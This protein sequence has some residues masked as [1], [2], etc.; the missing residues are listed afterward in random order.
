MINVTS[1]RAG[2]GYSLLS[3]GTERPLILLGRGTFWVL[4][5]AIPGEA[6]PGAG[7]SSLGLGCSCCVTASSRSA[8]YQCS[9]ESPERPPSPKSRGPAGGSSPQRGPGAGR[10]RSARLVIDLMTGIEAN[11]RR[12][13]RTGSSWVMMAPVLRFANQ[14]LAAGTCFLQNLREPCQLAQA[15]RCGSCR[16]CPVR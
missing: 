10:S 7:A 9:W 6:L 14:C 13:I 3:S 8:L 11:A 15:H 12:C 2:A 16:S 1:C 5:C 4:T